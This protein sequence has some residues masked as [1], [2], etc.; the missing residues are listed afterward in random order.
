MSFFQSLL[1]LFC[2]QAVAMATPPTHIGYS[3]EESIEPNIL[4]VR[5]S[6]VP[7]QGGILTLTHCVRSQV[8]N[9]TCDGETIIERP[10][11]SWSIPEDVKDLRWKIQLKEGKGVE[12]CEQ[13]SIKL[14]SSILLS[15]GSSLP[16][17]KDIYGPEGVRI[18]MPTVRTIY[19]EPGQSQSIALPGFS[20]PPLFLLLNFTERTLKDGLITLTYL[21]DDEKS[22]SLLPDMGE[23][24]K[25][26]KWLME[27]ADIKTKENFTVGWCEYVGE[28][29]GI[30]GATGSGIL[31][32]NYLLS[33]TSPI[34]KAL[35][36]YVV[37]HEAFHQ[38]QTY[39]P[40]E[41]TWIQESLASYYG[42]RAVEVIMPEEGASLMDRFQ[43]EADRFRKGL[44]TIHSAVEK[45][46][47]SEYA[48]FYTKGVAFWAEVDKTLRTRS[49]SLD[50]YLKDILSRMEY[51]QQGDPV[52]LNRILNLSQ[53]AW[54]SLRA[55]F[56]LSKDEKKLF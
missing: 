18:S 36:L 3:I 5:M 40:D 9:L 39:Y 23:N 41:P 31:L 25:G 37:L 29:L 35:M 6:P 8:T 16:Q 51:D 42:T 21:L 34:D 33:K 10:E 47:R 22:H 24:I 49:D 4:T 20:K 50:L 7:S 56:L 27:V 53:E 28:S 1:C 38:L 2:F 46:D 45:G 55:Q 44:L 54:L 15:G 43:K 19:P 26:L 11:G 52:N 48:A 17:F 12:A 13:Q 32:A 30:S 14:D